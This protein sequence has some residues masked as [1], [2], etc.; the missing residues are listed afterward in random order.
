MCTDF[1]IYVLTGIFYVSLG[2][3]SYADAV[4]GSPAAG[5]LVYTLHINLIAYRDIR[6]NT[7]CA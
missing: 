6:L 7:M 2:Y 5:K 3:R 1:I 4:R